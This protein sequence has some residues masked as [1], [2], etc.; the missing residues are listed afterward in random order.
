MGSEKRYRFVSNP[1]FL[2]LFFA[3]IFLSSL[4]LSDGLSNPYK[5]NSIPA[6][7]GFI[8]ADT[9]STTISVLLSIALLSIT[10]VSIFIVNEKIFS[11][12]KRSLSL[13]L[14]YLIFALSSPEAI[15]F[16]GS[17]AA[18]PLLLWSLFF[19]MN[20]KDGQKEL[21][22]AIF[23]ISCAS[24]MEI[25]LLYVIP[26]IFYYSLVNSSFALRSI[27]VALGAAITPYLFII[28]L[29][30]ILFDDA[31]IFLDL[32]ISEISNISV[33]Y[34]KLETFANLLLVLVMAV[35]SARSVISILRVIS[36]YKVVKSIGV[37]RNIT[38]ML[39]LIAVSLIYRDIQGAFTAIIAIPMSFVFLEYL[40]LK[41]IGKNRRIEFLILMIILALN[42][43]AEFL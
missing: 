31:A 42:R 14:F 1:L 21:F 8:E 20:T 5:L 10:S 39:L 41:E 38:L 40:A 22:S 18:A 26:F 12:G 30:H 33:P 2:G 3:G 25:H 9:L 43:V 36:R 37:V 16:T 29:R 34:L 4:Y 7:A 35:I 32:L 19:S 23:L 15:F 11:C 27:L 13:S 6:L 24:L 17:V 28:S